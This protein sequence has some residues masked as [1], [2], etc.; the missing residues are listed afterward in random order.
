MYIANG[1]LLVFV[2]FVV[3]ILNI[4]FAITVYAAQYHNWNF[5]SALLRL[6]LVCYIFI[7]LQYIMQLYW[8][9][10]IVK[11][12]L[13]SFAKFL[14]KSDTQQDTDKDKKKTG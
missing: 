4:P 2:F 7:G 10:L 9:I 12:A 11:L 8:F 14:Q 3:R 6:R 13:K 5:I 1:F